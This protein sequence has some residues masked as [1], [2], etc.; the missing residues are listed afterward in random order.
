MAFNIEDMWTYLATKA[1]EQ[2][3]GQSYKDVIKLYRWVQ[4]MSGL[5]MKEMMNTFNCGIGM[6]MIVNGECDFKNEWEKKIDALDERKK[7]LAHKLYHNF[8]YNAG[9][10]LFNPDDF[11]YLG[12]LGDVDSN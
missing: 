10:E 7:E 1:D 6:V 2:N 4:D 9:E 11:I 12:E 8:N 3:I 5:S